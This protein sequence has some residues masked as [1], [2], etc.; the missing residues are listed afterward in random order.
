MP[1][2][3]PGVMLEDMPGDGGEPIVLTLLEHE[4]D[5]TTGR[6][7]GDQGRAAAARDQGYERLRGGLDR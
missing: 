3:V 7:G 1:E 6:L 4:F 2:T 5:E